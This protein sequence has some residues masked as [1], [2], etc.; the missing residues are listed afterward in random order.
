MLTSCFCLFACI[1]KFEKVEVRDDA[2]KIT[3]S[4][5]I[6]KET[7]KRQGIYHR[8][9][10][11]RL[12]EESY[13]K[14]D[15]LDGKRYL[16]DEEGNRIIA[17]T[18]QAGIYHGPYYSYYPDGSIKIEGQYQA[19]TMEDVW[20]KYYAS[21][22]LM[23]KVRMHKNEENGPFIEYHENGNLKAE[24]SYLNGDNEHGE[25][26]LYDESGEL[27]RKMECNKGICHTTWTREKGLHA[28]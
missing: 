2:G 4:Y 11:E 28:N 23:E 3:E 12:V 16:F 17:E 6:D 15:T 27:E 22:Q 24:G 7:K 1:S 10:N 9:I 13:Y 5:T 18:Y 25:L 14:Q 21:G 26:L 19:G 8:F 20:T